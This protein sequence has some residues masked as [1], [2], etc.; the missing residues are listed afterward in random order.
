MSIIGQFF[1]FCQY[2]YLCV[3]RNNDVSF[4][5]DMATVFSIKKLLASKHTTLRSAIVSGTTSGSDQHLVPLLCSP[6]QALL[7]IMDTSYVLIWIISKS[8]QTKSIISSNGTQI[9]IS[10]QYQTKICPRSKLELQ[11][12]FS[13]TPTATKQMVETKRWVCQRTHL[14]SR[15]HKTKRWVL[16]QQWHRRLWRACS[17][18]SLRRELGMR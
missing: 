12:P 14:S 18:G 3:K 10:N 8:H 9:P 16:L 1:N 15:N 6:R 7:L 17:N 11:N 4:F 5:N 13:I 2:F